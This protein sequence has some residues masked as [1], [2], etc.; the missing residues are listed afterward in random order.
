ML[1]YRRCVG[2][3]TTLL[4]AEESAYVSGLANVLVCASAVHYFDFLFLSLSCQ[5]S[6]CFGLLH[7]AVTP[8]YLQL[9]FLY[10]QLIVHIF[11]LY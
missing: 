10:A 6:V 9:N 2:K 4:Q 8:K 1:N 5:L 3:K 11:A 7:L